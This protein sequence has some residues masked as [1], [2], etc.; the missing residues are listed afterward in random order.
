MH[1][2]GVFLYIIGIL[3]FIIFCVLLCSTFANISIEKKDKSLQ[4]LALRENE[5]ASKTVEFGERGYCRLYVYNALGNQGSDYDFK[6]FD[7]MDAEA[8]KIWENIKKNSDLF[9]PEF[10]IGDTASYKAA[11]K[12]I[13]WTS[14]MRPYEAEFLLYDAKAGKCFHFEFKGGAGGF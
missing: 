6:I 9:A 5:I 10:E 2:V 1:A 13:S 12:L 7:E 14:G 8:K 4:N 11:Y 3:T